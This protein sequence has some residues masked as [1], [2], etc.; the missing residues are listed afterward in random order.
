MTGLGERE[1]E[2]SGYVPA[3]TIIW[4]TPVA[5]SM[6]RGHRLGLKLIADKTSG[7]ILGAQAVGQSGAVSRI[8]T[9]STCLWSGMDLD[10]IG[11]MD[12]AY[13]PP[14]GGAW[15]IIHTA[16]QILKRQI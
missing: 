11:F 1:A 9:L 14:F 12:F 16:S 8:N 5:R 4:G 7:K 13:S 15:D 3:S 10:E 6:S 2:R